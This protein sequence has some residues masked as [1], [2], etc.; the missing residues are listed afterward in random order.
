MAAEKA[1]PAAPARG[2]E[3]STKGIARWSLFALLVA[4]TWCGATS[5]LGNRGEAFWLLVPLWVLAGARGLA[6]FPLPRARQQA[7]WARVTVKVFLIAFPVGFYLGMV[8]LLGG[9]VA[10][11]ELLLA[12]WFFALSL[13]ALLLYAFAALAALTRR[14][15]HGR[16][17]AAGV[18]VRSGVSLAFYALLV[19][20]LMAVFAVHRVKVPPVFPSDVFAMPHEDVRFAARGAPHV[21]LAGWFFPL[22]ENH[23][24]VLACHGV[25]A[26]RADILELVQVVRKAGF[27]V[28]CFDFRGHG[29][30][31]G[32][33]ITY[34][35][36]ERNDVLGAWD[37]LLARKDV[38]PER[39]FGLGVSMGGASLLMA[40][41]DL[42]RMRAVI[43]DS[44][45]SSLTRMIRHQ[46]R[47][48]PG[49]P[50]ELLARLTAFFGWVET[51]APIAAVD[52]AAAL[53][54]V[55]TP[56]FFIH[57][58]DDSIV[59]PECSRILHDGYGGPKQ[60]RLEPGAGHGR[61]AIADPLRYRRELKEFFLGR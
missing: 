17:R 13:E 53:R 25:G 43:A 20:F 6:L 36:E 30:S 24:T 28:L 31:D 35:W 8:V 50:G 10:W 1:N 12:V 44:A 39:I 40:L 54:G 59:P 58:L 21:T 55:K 38:D 41:R 15:V 46:Y 22:R 33:T 32:H 60:L 16:G 42:P 51:G 9:E 47:F 4:A 61:T 37:Y 5:W 18:A 26:N 19:P 7:R 52:P 29:A 49:P 11:R 14:L 27:Q 48:V 34:G 3:R 2:R 57:G 45:F 56:I 23:G